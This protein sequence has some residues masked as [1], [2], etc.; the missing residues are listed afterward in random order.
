MWAESHAGKETCLEPGFCEIHGHAA[1]GVNVVGCMMDSRRLA[2]LSHFDEGTVTD[3]ERFFHPIH[4]THGSTILTWLLL[5]GS[6]G[7]RA[8]QGPQA[9]TSPNHSLRRATKRLTSQSKR[10]WFLIDL[11]V[12]GPDWSAAKSAKMG[13]LVSCLGIASFDYPLCDRP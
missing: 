10:T 5:W 12:L 8:Q 13:V 3:D 9:M 2:C 1:F 11:I 7:S 4:I 6:L